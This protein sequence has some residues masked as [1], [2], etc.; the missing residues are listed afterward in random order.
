MTSNPTPIPVHSN[1]AKYFGLDVH[2]ALTLS[3]RLYGILFTGIPLGALI[4][5]YV[6]IIPVKQK[7]LS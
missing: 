1:P 2:E 4:A 3:T 7:A 5:L 6:L